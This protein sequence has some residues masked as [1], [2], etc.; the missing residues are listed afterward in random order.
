[1][2]GTT[3]VGTTLYPNHM[4]VIAAVDIGEDNI[5]VPGYRGILY[6][7]SCLV[8]L[9]VTPIELGGSQHCTY[10][11]LYVVDTGAVGRSFCV[12]DSKP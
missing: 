10:T 2:D 6:F 7:F 8:G 3:V 1:M 5:P 12:M 11:V 4:A 9:P